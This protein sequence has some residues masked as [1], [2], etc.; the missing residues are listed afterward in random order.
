MFFSH[1]EC[2]VPC[3]AGPF[4]ARER[5]HTCPSCGMPL[6]ARYDMA[7]ARHWSRDSLAGRRPDMWRYLEMLPIFPGETPIALGEGYTPLLRTERL[8]QMVGLSRL[9]IKDE[10]FN[11]TNSF[12]ARGQATAVTRAKVLGATT[13]TLPTAGNAGNAAA[14]YAAAADIRCEIFMP[15]D[16]KQPFIDECLLYGANIT[17]VDGL[18]TDAG[19][20][21]GE[22]ARELGWYDVST[23]KEPYRAEGKKTMGY[24]IAE[25]LAWEL[26]DWII[27][28]TG[29]GT[30]MVGMWK[31]FEEMEAMGW[32]GAKRP[33]MV[34]VQPTGCAPIV[35]AFQEGT[36]RAAMWEHP[37]TQAHGLRVPKAIGDF[38]VLR[39]IRESGG[40]A[41]MVT[42]RQMVDDML[43]IGRLEGISAAPEGAA[44]LSAARLLLQSGAMRPDET[45]VL[46]NTGGALK[47]LE[48]LRSVR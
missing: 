17:L 32:I 36:E 16:A 45:V 40:T 20:M 28:P 13:I 9:Y 47:Y 24:E 25:Q 43:L 7:R 30:G 19:K 42:D 46:F 8:G 37:D 22:K 6:F 3:G 44:A 27:Y 14:A 11:P 33:K 18:I 48:V 39:A 41:L 35:R 12:K 21:A 2:S 4:A 38:L 29:G 31:A 34:T 1:L 5:H 10:A 23:L 15:R 26:P